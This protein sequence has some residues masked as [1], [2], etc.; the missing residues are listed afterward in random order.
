MKRL[1]ITLFATML[2]G[3]VCAQDFAIKNNVLYDAALTP[4]LGVEF[5]LGKAATMDISGNW[6]PFEFNDGKKWKHWLVQ[7]E[8]RYWFCESFNG[9][10]IGIHGHVGEINF[11]NI[12]LPFGLRPGL[13]YYRY[14]GWFYGGGISLGYQWVLSKRWSIETVLGFGY[15]RIDYKQ[16]E[17][18]DCGQLLRSGTENYVGLTKAAVSFLFFL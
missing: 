14:E 17:P 11:A 16:Y 5:R 6:N 10:F 13:E 8:F 15:A 1:L 2:T 4:N 3:M 18:I 7:P 9:A 12:K